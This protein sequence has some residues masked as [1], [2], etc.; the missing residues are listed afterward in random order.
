[1]GSIQGI[2]GQNMAIGGSGL[3][4]HRYFPGHSGP[5]GTISQDGFAQGTAGQHMAIG[6]LGK[7][8]GGAHIL[9]GHH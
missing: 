5:Y 9:A 4:V 8:F 1:M 7:Y 3:M 2:A 6:V